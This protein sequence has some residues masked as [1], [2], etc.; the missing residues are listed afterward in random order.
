MRQRK[1][2]WASTRIAL[3][4][5]SATASS[6]VVVVVVV[7]VAAASVPSSSRRGTA[8]T[9]TH[10][11]GSRFIPCR[12]GVQVPSWT[13]GGVRPVVV[14]VVVSFVAVVGAEGRGRW[15]LQGS[16]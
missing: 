11:S 15:G 7:V 13:D 3:A 6:F 1:R 14:V 5:A 12:R 16:S 9:A 10:V 2:V 4:S 8:T